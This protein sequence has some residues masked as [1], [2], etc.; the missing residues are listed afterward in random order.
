MIYTALLAAIELLAQDTCLYL[1]VDTLECMGDVASGFFPWLCTY[2]G[3]SVACRVV[4]ATSREPMD[5]AQFPGADIRRIAPLSERH[6][7]EV[8]TELVA[9]P[10]N[11]NEVSATIHGL[12]GG[13]HAQV[14]EL[15][16]RIIRSQ[17]F[18]LDLQHGGVRIDLA[19]TQELSRTW[20]ALPD[21]LSARAS[22]LANIAA[23]YG[24]FI[25][26]P[27]LERVLQQVRPELL[28]ADASL[29]ELAN[30]GILRRDEHGYR[31]AHEHQ[32]RRA[33]AAVI[34]VERRLFHQGFALALARRPF[35]TRDYIRIGTHW[36]AAGEPRRALA[37]LSLGAKRA[38]RALAVRDAVDALERA[39]QLAGSANP[40]VWSARA[41]RIASRLLEQLSVVGNHERL[42]EIADRLAVHAPETARYAHARSALLAAQSARIVGD[43][44]AAERALARSTAAVPQAQE[45]LSRKLNGVWLD[46]QIVGAFTAYT[47]RDLFTMR[48]RLANLA[49]P[50]R[51][52]GTADQRAGFLVWRA[53]YHALKSRYAFN[54]VCVR[55]ERHALRIL[56]R[57]ASRSS[58]AAYCQFDLAFMLLLGDE[59]ACRE[60]SGL[61][62]DTE[63]AVKQLGDN[64]LFARVATY[65][66]I[67]LRR[68]RDVRRCEQYAKLAL[69]IAQHCGLRGY[70]GAVYGCLA[71]IALRS[72]EQTR[73][74]SLCQTA[75]A[76]FQANAGQATTEYPF[77]WLSLFP[78]LAV[79]MS[80]DRLE[81]AYSAVPQMLRDSQAQ[82]AVPV[83]R[84]LR[85]IQADIGALDDAGL[86][87][88]LAELVRLATSHRY[89]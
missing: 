75:D 12:T 80:E 62:F 82:L 19:R 27:L 1:L 4:I 37:Y 76:H 46:T 81:H 23:L 86:A 24:S 30:V 77:Q 17:A 61:L 36:E 71:W 6:V 49:K 88:R 10:R 42:A 8:L 69:P 29:R 38:A 28:P 11:A 34:E 60:A 73:T 58:A 7:A 70:L 48:R 56:S 59:T 20:E 72:G 84:A 41:V 22:S 13:N 35:R 66:T 79:D 14:V 39:L 55:L 89:L 52:W 64:V 33:A 25:D 85:A 65:Q 3:H 78:Q 2:L 67:A 87:R 47:R 83:D 68:L 50:V 15:L 32:R 44:V 40:G 57:V 16:T 54:P 43:Y 5:M 21:G 26:V 51:R 31:F 53:N 74:L 18:E 63:R 45:T 9:H